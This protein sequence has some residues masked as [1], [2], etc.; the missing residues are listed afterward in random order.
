MKNAKLSSVSVTYLLSL[1]SVYCMNI[2]QANYSNGHP[3]NVSQPAINP[4]N[5]TLNNLNLDNYT[6]PSVFEHEAQSNPNINLSH[7]SLS[8]QKIGPYFS[9]L[10]LTNINISDSFVQ[11]LNNNPEVNVLIADNTRISLTKD[12]FKKS[13]KLEVLSLKFNK[14]TKLPESFGESLENLV[15]LDLEGNHLKSLDSAFDSNFSNL[16]TLSLKDNKLESLS[17]KFGSEMKQLQTLDLSGNNLTELHSNFGKELEQ[18]TELDLSENKLE[19]ISADFCK[20]L[21]HIERLSLKNNLLTSLPDSFIESL[22]NL[23]SIDLSGNKL[24]AQINEESKN[25]NCDGGLLNNLL[26][27]QGNAKLEKL[28]SLKLSGMSISKL[29]PSFIG[30]LKSIKVFNLSNNKLRTL[31]ANIQDMKDTLEVLNLSDNPEL[32][33]RGEKGVSVGKQ[34]LIR[35]FG[36]RVVFESDNVYDDSK[37]NQ[38]EIKSNNE[39]KQ[40]HKEH[41]ILDNV[42]LSVVDKVAKA[43]F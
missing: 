18:L 21:A 6:N 20:N 13:K 9:S 38:N 12:T 23:H 34:E 22:P 40:D 14:L 28:E 16:S 11:I 32:Q 42:I 25:N 27:L 10:N 24:V 8:A 19:S 17:E 4:V 7:P 37:N 41:P 30:S 35:I 31:P 3:L 15:A 29:S 36:K 26:C 33:E 43:E 5:L 2:M 1:A 39:T